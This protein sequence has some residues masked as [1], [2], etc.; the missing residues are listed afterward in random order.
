MLLSVLYVGTEVSDS[1][2]YL[3]EAV[4]NCLQQ[5]EFL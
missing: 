4:S 2:V 1:A 3:L 5:D